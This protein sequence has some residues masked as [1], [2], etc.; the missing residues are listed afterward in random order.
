MTAGD[1]VNNI[2]TYIIRIFGLPPGL[3]SAL[4]VVGCRVIYVVL[5][6]THKPASAQQ[7]TKL[8]YGPFQPLDRGY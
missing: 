5:L 2:Q 6:H 8:V 4:R 7:Q 1:A 3:Q